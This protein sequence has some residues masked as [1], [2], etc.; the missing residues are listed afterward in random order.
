MQMSRVN[1]LSTV[2]GLLSIF[3]KLKTSLNLAM[4]LRASRELAF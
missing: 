3:S 1:E 4:Q 2:P